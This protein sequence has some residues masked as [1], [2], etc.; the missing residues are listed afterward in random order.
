MHMY[1]LYTYIA[2]IYIYIYMYKV[3][4]YIH[5]YIRVQRRDE[6]GRSPPRACSFAG[7]EGRVGEREEEGG[8]ARVS[9]A[10]YA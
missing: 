6:M 1:T 3:Y 4:P 5:T 7:K 2:T 9:P 10:G 8:G